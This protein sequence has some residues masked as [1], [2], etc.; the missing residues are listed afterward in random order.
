M[1]NVVFRKATRK[2]AKL[3]L[4][5]AAPSGYGKTYSALLLAAG[6]GGKVAMI[7]TENGSGDLYAEDMKRDHGLEYDIITMHAPYYPEKYTAAIKAAED[8][9]YDI[10]I[11]D[12]LTHAWSGEGGLLDQQG[13]IA[14]SSRGNS[15]TAW[16]TITPKHNALVEA[17]LGSSLHIIATMRSKVDYVLET[18]ERGKQ[19]PKKVGLAPI[20]REGMDYEFT[21]VLDVDK[22][23]Y[24]SPSKD[25][26]SMFDNQFIKMT[27]EIGKQL[28][29]WLETG[30]D[31]PK[32]PPTP[33]EPPKPPSTPPTTPNT[34][35]NEATAGAPIRDNQAVHVEGGKAYPA[36]TS[37]SQPV[38]PVDQEPIKNDHDTQLPRK[39]LDEAQNITTQEEGNMLLADMASLGESTYKIKAV[40]AIVKRR[41]AENASD[42]ND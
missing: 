11:I 41:V 31:E 3:R 1:P 4:A 21:V 39:W 30:E 9:G 23:H 18:D 13:K 7:D 22:N 28:R 34:P 29:T 32:E 36:G 40:E 26:T 5:L 19:V 2:K 38:A 17:M 14:D 10:L 15:Y 33:T 35:V 25:R 16:R 20:Q 24:A 37:P 8:A 12:S 6:L 42:V 27:P